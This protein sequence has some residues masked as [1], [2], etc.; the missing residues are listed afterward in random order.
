MVYINF[1]HRGS[2]VN[3]TALS[4][5][6]LSSLS[7]VL[8]THADGAGD[9]DAA[10]IVLENCEKEKR[11]TS[12]V[13]GFLN[14]EKSKRMG[15]NYPVTL[16]RSI[17]RFGNYFN[18]LSQIEKDLVEKFKIE[19][20]EKR[21]ASSYEDLFNSY[22]NNLNLIEV[23]DSDGE[24]EKKSSSCFLIRSLVVSVIAVAATAYYLR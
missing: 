15:I 3:E 24:L 4:A 9:R 11:E 2:W 5:G 12:V 8:R 20:I 13:L 14:S 23:I 1:N 21:P 6:S 7:K 10:K 19:L 17:Q 22:S 16:Q 18:D